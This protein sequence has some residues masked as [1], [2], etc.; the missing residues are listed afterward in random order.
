LQLLTIIVGEWLIRRHTP[1]RSMKI[2]RV[3]VL[4]LVVML[5]MTGC[6]DDAVGDA[7]GADDASGTTVI[8][9]YYNNTT[10]DYY[11]NN[12]TV[13]QQVPDIISL[14]G[15]IENVT[16]TGTSI[17]YYVATINSS[18]GEL[19]QLHEAQA[20][21][22]YALLTLGWWVT[23]STLGMNVQSSCISNGNE[24]NFVLYASSG[25]VDEHEY[26]PGSAFNCSHEIVVI[27]GS[28]GSNLDNIS[29]SFTYSVLPTIVG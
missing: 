3:F 19:I 29:W 7:E 1:V 28:G 14:G 5:P 27:D 2:D 6:F 26:L 22:V 15:L 12:T 11:N 8:N 16:Y 21:Q 10:T 20:Q 9:N 13:L 25:Q 17:P 4:L 24:V 18:A 23:D